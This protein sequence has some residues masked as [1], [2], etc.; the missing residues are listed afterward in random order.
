MKNEMPARTIAVIGAGPAGLM[1]ADT[2]A[3]GWPAQGLAAQASASPGPSGQDPRQ[4]SRGTG[5]QGAPTGVEILVFDAMPA[6]ARKFLLAGRG[7]LNLTHSEPLPDFLTRYAA[8]PAQLAAALE[9]FPPSALRALA[10]DLGAETFVGSSGRV[11]PRAMK[12]S[13]LLR[14][15]LARLGAAG[16]RFFPRHRWQGWDE[17]GRLLFDTSPGRVTVTADATVLALGGASW[18]R[19]GS[20][21]DWIGHLAEAAEVAPFE[22][23]N[24][25]ILCGWSAYVA[26]KFAG[27]PLK[28]IA[29]SIGGR[30]RRGEAILT[31]QGLEG[32]AVYALVPEI[33]AALAAGRPVTVVLDLRPD[34][35]VQALAARLGAARGKESLASFLRKAAG[36]PPVALALLRESGAVPNDPGALAARLKALPVPVQALAGLERAISSAGGVRFSALNDHLMLIS[37]PGVFLAGEMLDWEA[38]TG[39]YLLQACFATGRAAGLGVL[40]HLGAVSCD[41]SRGEDAGRPR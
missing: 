41:A 10:D 31:R 9:A 25:G 2:I 15:I 1:A 12:A 40:Q 28:R 11:F 19:L 5:E 20:R 24:C 21:G 34:V 3:R 26:E 33:R 30:T 35:S 8:L 37:R 22:P 4:Q 23:A 38:P 32:G 36:L 7:G 39:G 29:L 6:P 27:T 14:A 16:V 13:P 17:A 18:P